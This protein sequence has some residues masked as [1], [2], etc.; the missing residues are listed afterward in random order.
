MKI[1]TA[2]REG[3]ITVTLD[4]PGRG[5]LDLTPHTVP[6]WTTAAVGGYGSSQATLPGPPS[7]WKSQIPYL[8]VIRIRFGPRILFEGRIEDIGPT[9][10]QGQLN[11]KIQGF[12]WRRLLD[13]TSVRR[14][15]SKRDLGFR[16]IT[17]AKGSTNYGA[18]VV[19]PARWNVQTG[20]IEPTDLSLSG[21][22]VDGIDG[23]GTA[24]VGEGHMGEWIFPIGLTL[25]RVLFDY[26]PSGNLSAIDQVV[27]TSADGNTWSIIAENSVAPSSSP[28]SVNQG[29]A[30]RQTQVRF[31]LV[32]NTSFG[33]LS[34][35]WLRYQNIRFL[36]TSI[37][38]DT[39]GGF[40]GGTLLRDLIALV[41][42]LTI[43]QIDVGS[44]FTIQAIERAIR[45]AAASVVEEIAGY[46]TR[47]WAVWED[48]RFDW[49]APNLDEPNWIV[50]LP[51]LSELDLTGSIDGI[52]RTS[53]LLY[54]D[55]PTGLDAEASAASTDQRNPFV[56]QAGTKDALV[57]PGF[58]MTSTS[59]SQLATKLASETGK[60]P[61]VNGRIVLPAHTLVRNPA[62]TRQPAYTI[63]GGE[64]ILIADLPKS[65][66]LQP[67][68]DGETL[69]HIVSSD[70]DLQRGHVTLELEG[71]TRRADILLA[72]LAAAT[73]T[74][75]G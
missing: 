68:R 8:S 17:F 10:A 15:W 39:S 53:Y 14:I 40:Y 12:G 18:F 54:S 2:G 60:W 67:G 9:L 46:Y 57:S 75:T 32:V 70:T 6:R 49:K 28:V 5:P 30:G 65:D 33:V 51:D 56:K 63:R 55:A 72:R 11:T 22:R 23:G 69:F 19:A 37:V 48:G 21:V 29:L 24:S 31:G 3:E 26:V 45:S 1:T 71:Q 41:P 59:A 50:E 38:E 64:N 35:Y 16:P 66:V 44:D 42:G 4:R 27:L 73:R 43:G 34:S 25:E 47:E 61:P 36:G 74:L 13:D 52:A 20:P 62:G 7:R 58:P